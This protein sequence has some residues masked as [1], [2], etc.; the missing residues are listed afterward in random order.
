MASAYEQ[1][2]ADMEQ[3][4]PLSENMGA[5]STWTEPGEPPRPDRKLSWLKGL[6]FLGVLGVDHFY[7][8]SPLTGLAKLLTFGGVGLWWIWDILQVWTEGDRVVKNG[9][10]M[11]FDLGTGIGQGMITNTETHYKQRSSFS[12]WQLAALFGF[13]GMDSF[14]LGK[15][16]QGARK[17][18]EFL[19]FA[20]GVVSL[21]LAYNADGVSGLIT[22]GKIITALIVIFFG[23]IV[24]TNWGVSLGTI[25]ERPGQFF[26][27]G[28]NVTQKMRDM[29]NSYTGIL[30][31]YTFMP[32][33]FRDRVKTDM[34]YGSI[35]GPEMKARFAIEHEEKLSQE[36]AQE[37]AA[38]A[39]PTISDN[40]WI[41]SFLVWILLPV[42][43]IGQIGYS[44]W[45]LTPWG[46]AT[47]A[48]GEITKNPMGA[49]AS[50]VPNPLAGAI[51]VPLPSLSVP[52]PLSQA[53]PSAP[54]ATA[55][56]WAS[57][58]ASAVQQGT[59]QQIGG[60]RKSELS[61]E[62]LVLGA[63]V[64]AIVGGGALKAAVD[65][66]VAE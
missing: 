40:K 48:F 46:R 19:F 60:A 53:M 36:T 25:T 37:A 28:I 56:N 12:L 22:F 39:N 51:P 65:Y 24:L 2:D 9:L 64:I 30:D 62:A 7:L 16:G 66:L 3:R 50:M 42:L 8:R 5:A 35:P 23:G 27:T 15:W 21:V 57:L 6:T 34:N 29:L 54:P 31:N 49:V 10:T 47:A 32:D 1:F 38:A 45:S 44:I 61:T 18:T 59:N 33:Y 4:A 17:I 55:A 26:T 14:L 41:L 58:A 13:V 63:A 52:V 20:M 43:A 11:P